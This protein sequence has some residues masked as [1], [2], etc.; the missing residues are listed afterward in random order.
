MRQTYLGVDASYGFAQNW[1]L[2]GSAVYRRDA[3]IRLSTGLA[4]A[5]GGL[6]HGERD[7]KEWAVGLRYYGW[8]NFALNVEFLKTSGR[9]AFPSESLT[10]TGRFGF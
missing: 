9:E 8:R 3:D 4:S 1:Q 2:H 7:E 5:T 10:F 6:A